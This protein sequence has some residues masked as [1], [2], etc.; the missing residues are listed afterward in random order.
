ML[1]LQQVMMQQQ[2]Q[3]KSGKHP[4]AGWTTGG[5]GTTVTFTANK[6]GARS[7]TTFTDTGTTGV[8]ATVTR[9]Q[10]WLYWQ[11]LQAA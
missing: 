1:Q 11:R 7:A 3:P 6:V 8:T 9:T 2:L 5:S 4:F 10:C